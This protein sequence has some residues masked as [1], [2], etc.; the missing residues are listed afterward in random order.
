MT[1]YFSRRPTPNYDYYDYYYDENYDADYYEDYYEG[2]IE[3]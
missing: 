2:R 1:I 3:K